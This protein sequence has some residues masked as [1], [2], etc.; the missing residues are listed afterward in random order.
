MEFS[1]LS[2][3]LPLFLFTLIYCLSGRLYDRIYAFT[4]SLSLPTSTT[5]TTQYR[6]V[7]H[8]YSTS[9]RLRDLSGPPKNT[10]K[11]HHLVVPTTTRSYNWSRRIMANLHFTPSA[12]DKVEN[13][14]NTYSKAEF[15]QWFH[16][17]F[18]H[19]EE[20]WAEFMWDMHARL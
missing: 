19:I 6:M 18:P 5:P 2:V 20:T 12:A 17:K 1:L 10:L 7:P 9:L 4:S 11:G 13:A 8:S 15:V 3:S 14:I 16:I